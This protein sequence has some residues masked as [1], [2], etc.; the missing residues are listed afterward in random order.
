[1]LLRKA[2]EYM[3][4]AKE[5]DRDPFSEFMNYCKALDFCKVLVR[6]KNLEHIGH[7]AESGYDPLREPWFQKCCEGV[8][9]LP[10]D[11]D[12]GKIWL[13]GHFPYNETIH[14]WFCEAAD[15]THVTSDLRH[16]ESLLTT[17][18]ISNTQHNE[19]LY[20]LNYAPVL[21]EKWHPQSVLAALETGLDTWDRMAVMAAKSENTKP[22][23]KVR[24]TWSADDITR[25]LTSMYDRQG[26]PLSSYYK[27][28]T[29]R[30]SDLEVN[31]IFDHEYLQR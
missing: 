9:M 22:N 23:E 6:V 28:V 3:L 30:K 21:S 12:W 15:V 11:K 31:A 4:Q 19:L 8:L 7:K 18:A 27:G 1:M 17:N 26:I 13:E 25:E 2:T 29:A 10:E 14:T 16:Y 5:V 24:E 20:A